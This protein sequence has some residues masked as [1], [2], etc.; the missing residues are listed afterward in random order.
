MDVNGYT[1]SN[2]IQIRHSNSIKLLIAN[3]YT[4]FLGILYGET[5]ASITRLNTIHLN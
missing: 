1:L 2:T 5:L 4:Q 3:A